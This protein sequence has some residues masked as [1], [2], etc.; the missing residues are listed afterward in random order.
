MTIRKRV[1]A[2][3]NISAFIGSYKEGFLML[4]FDGDYLVLWLSDVD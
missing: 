1:A 2:A 4:E 3:E